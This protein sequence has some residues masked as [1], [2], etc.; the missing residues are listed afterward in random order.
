MLFPD[1]R[2]QYK[3]GSLLEELQKKRDEKT[4]RARQLGYNPYT[5]ETIPYDQRVSTPET[6]YNSERD[7]KRYVPEPVPYAKAKPLQSILETPTKDELLGIDHLSD[8]QETLKRYE[9]PNLWGKIRGKIQDLMGANKPALWSP[10]KEVEV[11]D[12]LKKELRTNPSEH[13]YLGTFF[14]TALPTKI[15]RSKDEKILN[16]ARQELADEY[17]Q[18][19]P[20]LSVVAEATGVIYNLV[21]LKKAG[22]GLGV[23]EKITSTIG[24]AK[25]LAPTLTR[26]LASG[27]E[28]AILYGVEGALSEYFNQRSTNDFNA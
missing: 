28:G 27:T 9:A 1:K 15:L 14:D 16:E 6:T 10:T 22:A 13:G 11:K 26:Y 3:S 2:Q 12:Y 19:N 20:V 5:K 8:K 17:R 7:S 24:R 21:L 18:E 25:H 23:G 4:A